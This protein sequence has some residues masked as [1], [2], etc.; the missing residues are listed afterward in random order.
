VVLALGRL[1]KATLY[2]VEPF[3]PVTF[4]SAA[5]LLLLFAAL[6]ATLPGRRASML[7]PTAALRRE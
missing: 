2:G 1:T 6:A 4:G 5:L 7:D 3:D